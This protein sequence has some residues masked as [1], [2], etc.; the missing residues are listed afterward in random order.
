[1]AKLRFAHATKNHADLHC[2]G[3]CDGRITRGETVVVLE[4]SRFVPFNVRTLVYH[5]SCVRGVL[6]RNRPRQVIK[7]VVPPP[8]TKVDA[9]RELADVY[10]AAQRTPTRQELTDWMEMTAPDRDLMRWSPNDSANE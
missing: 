1:M 6:P 9:V 2:C 7:R 4:Q 8:K 10:H 3:Q 5:E